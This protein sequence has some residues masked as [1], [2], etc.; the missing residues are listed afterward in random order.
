MRESFL[1][2]LNGDQ[3]T[4]VV[5]SADITYW[6]DGSCADGRADPHLQSEIGL[7]ELSREL[8]MMPYYW[9]GKFWAAEP[10][11]DSRIEILSTTEGKR[12]TIIWQTPVGVISAEWTRLE[13]CWSE[14]PTRYAVQN[15]RDLEVLLYLLEHRRLEP[16]NLDDFRQRLD[17]WARY[18]GVPCLG[19][20]RSPLPAFI[21]DWA[22]VEHGALLLMDD[23]DKV[24]EVLRLMTVQEQ[25]VLEAVTELKPPLVAF[26][27]NLSS[28]NLT[29]FFDAHMAV[30]YRQRLDFLH[31]AGVRC[32][33][34]LD[35]R[36]RG[37]LPRLAEVGFDAVE[38]LTPKPAG[39]VNVNDMRALAANDRVVLWGG[40]PGPMFVPPY[41]W[42]DVRRHVQ[43][44]LSAWANSPFVLGVGDQVPP[45]GSLDFVRKISDLIRH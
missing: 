45:N 37:L 19:L 5:W 25:P 40:I 23:P 14:A 21:S 35:G 17:L 12:R 33:V 43:T 41:T 15:E 32:A 16:T 11:Y 30:R 4:E 44:L 3:P 1:Q 7:L 18:D 42:D 31:A 13:G 39:D 22:G 2:L 9:Y 28:D 24:E 29:S 38:A 20:P 10:R 27:D 26:P 8:G 34:H 6:V 36:V